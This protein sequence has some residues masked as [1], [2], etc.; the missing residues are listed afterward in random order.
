[1]A[2]VKVQRAWRRYTLR[3]VLDR[4]VL[5]SAATEVQLVDTMRTTTCTDVFPLLKHVF[6][7]FDV[8]RWKMMNSYVT[9]ELDSD[10]QQD[11]ATEI[12]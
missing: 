1:M 6:R 2:S 9:L 11:S 4:V 12:L 3:T 7:P 5:A 8:V 10:V